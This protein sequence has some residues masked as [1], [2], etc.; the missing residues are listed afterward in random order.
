MLENQNFAE[1]LAWAETDNADEV[2]GRFLLHFGFLSIDENKSTE[3]NDSMFN[4]PIL[5]AIDTKQPGFL[6]DLQALDRL[7]PRKNDTLHIFYVK[8]GQT[9]ANE[10]ISNVSEANLGSLAG[11]LKLKN[12]LDGLVS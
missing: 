2:L 10:I 7:S 8:V 6:T 12:T 4:F 9:S 5:T 11:P 1:K 3:E